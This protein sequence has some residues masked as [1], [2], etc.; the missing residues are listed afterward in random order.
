[1]KSRFCEDPTGA[2]EEPGKGPGRNQPQNLIQSVGALGTPSSCGGHKLSRDAVL[3]GFTQLKC[4]FLKLS[5]PHG[6]VVPGLG[7]GTTQRASRKTRADVCVVAPRIPTA[8]SA[9]L[10]AE[11]NY[12]L[13]E[14]N[15]CL[16]FCC[17]EQQAAG[18]LP[19]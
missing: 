19:G 17:A 15:L 10:E 13:Q 18:V 16:V 1:M 6:T 12:T 7:A 5:M 4:E 9:I 3:Q 14:Q 2:E 8:F 11:E